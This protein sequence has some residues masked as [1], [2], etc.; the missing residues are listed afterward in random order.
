MLYRKSPPTPCTLLLRIVH[1]AGAGALLGATACGSSSA[2]GSAPVPPS[3]DDS[4]VDAAG[5]C[6][7]G[8][9]GI[10]VMPHDAGDTGTDGA[11]EP[12][13]RLDGNDA[14]PCGG[15]FCGTVAMPD[16]SNA[17]SGDGGGDASSDSATD[18]HGPCNPCGL[19]LNP[20][21]GVD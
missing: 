2:L 16:A 7:G 21:A 6:G 15:G 20:D 10:M 12:D 5:P 8:P 3:S 9:C 18:A 13:E 11:G 17:S 4:G 19:I 1:T 14:G